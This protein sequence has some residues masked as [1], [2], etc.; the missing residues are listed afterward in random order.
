MADQALQIRQRELDTIKAGDGS[1]AQIEE[2]RAKLDL[3]IVAVLGIDEEIDRREK[4]LEQFS[5]RMQALH[6]E[7]SAVTAQAEQKREQAEVAL[8]ESVWLNSALHPKN[9][10]RWGLE[11]G[12][13]YAR[14]VPHRI[15]VARSGPA[16]CTE[17]CAG[18]GRKGP[19][20]SAERDHTCRH[21]RIEFR[22]CG[23]DGHRH[24][25]TA[26]HIRSSRN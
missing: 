25:R 18:Y 11:P 13:G 1:K 20:E 4:I 24:H 6:D 22:Q 14:R 10:M 15:C 9:I 7:Q 16:L 2:A 19:Q 3:V 23:D 21:T 17:Y 12:A 26:A 5:I 8:K